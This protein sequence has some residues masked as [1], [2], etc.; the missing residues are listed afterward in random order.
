MNIKELKKNIKDFPDDF[1]AVIHFYDDDGR[2][3]IKE[4]NAIS[5]MVGDKRVSFGFESFEER[6][7]KN[8]KKRG[9]FKFEKKGSY[10]QL[11]N[12]H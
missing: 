11:I 2:I 7:Y 5:M 4:L 3:H 1:K 8:L 6:M 10:D 9:Y 12:D